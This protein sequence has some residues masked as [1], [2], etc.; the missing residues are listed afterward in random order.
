VDGTVDDTVKKVNSSP[1]I[2][3]LAALYF[4]VFFK[5]AYF[6]QTLTPKSSINTRYNSV[7]RHVSSYQVKSTPGWFVWGA[8]PPQTG[9]KIK[10][11]KSTVGVSVGN[12]TRQVEV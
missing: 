7:Q 6:P 11:R 12:Q 9:A 8:P 1:A 4:G 3:L 2:M 10:N 5:G